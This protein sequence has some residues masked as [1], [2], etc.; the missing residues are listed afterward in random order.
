M[1]FENYILKPKYSVWR[2]VSEI[3]KLYAQALAQIQKDIAY[4]LARFAENNEIDM[5]EARKLLKADELEEFKWTL[6]EYIK[7]GSDE[8]LSK[9]WMKELENASVKV[10]ISRL[11]ALMKQCLLDIVSC[12]Q[13]AN[14]KLLNA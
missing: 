3:K 5:T 10:H 4:W 2:T 8:N 12:T 14:G 1:F 7:N 6:E 13:F 11:E 9:E